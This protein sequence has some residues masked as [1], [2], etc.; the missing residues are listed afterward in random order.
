MIGSNPGKKLILILIFLSVL[1]LA[2]IINLDLEGAERSIS[3]KIKLKVVVEQKICQKNPQWQK[4]IKTAVKRASKYYDEYYLKF[5]VEKFAAMTEEQF[6]LRLKQDG[7]AFLKQDIEPD[8]CDVV[9]IIAT[10][11]PRCVNPLADLFLSRFTA[12]Y[13]GVANRIGGDEFLAV[14]ELTKEDIPQ[15][16]WTIVHEMGHILGAEHVGDQLSFMHPY[17]NPMA[18][19]FDQKNAEIILKNKLRFSKK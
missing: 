4:D 16:V 1:F 3:V 19:Y 11:F 12:N 17:F 15:L 10:H 6:Q 2:D 14:S 13:V 18:I 8:G 7:P 5:S 9:F